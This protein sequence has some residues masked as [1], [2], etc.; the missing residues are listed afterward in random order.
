MMF[1]KLIA[2]TFGLSSSSSEA[3]LPS[4]FACSNSVLAASRSFIFAT[5]T[6]SLIFIRIE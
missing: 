1:A 6:S 5:I 4:F 3:L 2:N